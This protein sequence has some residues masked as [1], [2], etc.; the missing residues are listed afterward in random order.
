MMPRTFREGVDDRSGDEPG[1][2]LG[3][4]LE[5]LGAQRDQPVQSCSHVVDVPV[6]DRS[7]RVCCKLWRGELPVDNAQLVLVVAD[8]ELD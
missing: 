4:R 8:A 7:A 3:G 2:A 5:L 1:A 6:D